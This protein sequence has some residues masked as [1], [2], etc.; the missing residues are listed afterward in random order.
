MWLTD[1][2]ISKSFLCHHCVVL[3]TVYVFY[4]RTAQ[5]RSQHVAP[6]C[7]LR[8]SRPR[9]LPR[10]PLPIPTPLKLSLLARTPA[11]PRL[12]PRCCYCCCCCRPAGVG[13]LY[14]RR[15]NGWLHTETAGAY[16]SAC[17]IFSWADGCSTRCD[18]FNLVPRCQVSRCQVSSFQRPRFALF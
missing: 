14:E 16:R 3:C 13:T 8:N 9:L 10:L 7:T 15:Q 17:S 6:R 2:T 1:R 4:V 18:L 12:R 5:A 11:C